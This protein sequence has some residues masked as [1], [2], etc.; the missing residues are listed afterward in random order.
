M[1][2]DR[3]Q[4]KYTDLL[5]SVNRCTML[6]GAVKG[7]ENIR[8]EVSGSLPMKEVFRMIIL[9]VGLAAVW[10]QIYMDDML[11]AASFGDPCSC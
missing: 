9:L 6:G 3:K 5:F 8:P 7:R 1:V 11:E 10:I 2:S 4:T